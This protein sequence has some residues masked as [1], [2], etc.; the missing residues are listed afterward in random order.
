M[1]LDNN[2]GYFYPYCLS[3]VKQKQMLARVLSVQ[4][5]RTLRILITKF[6]TTQ[7]IQYN[8]VKFYED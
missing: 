2:M 1:F 6:Q 4:V 8:F 5:E 7:T 3:N